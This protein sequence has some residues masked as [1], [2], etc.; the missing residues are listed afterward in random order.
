MLLLFALK[1]H[2]CVSHE[3]GSSNSFLHQESQHFSPD[4][5]AIC[6]PNVQTVTG[7]VVHSSRC[8]PSGSWVIFNGRSIINTLFFSFLHSITGF[9]NRAGCL[10]QAEE[11]MDYRRGETGVTCSP[12]L[13]LV[14]CRGDKDHKFPLAHRQSGKLRVHPVR[15]QSKGLAGH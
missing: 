3:G 11:K 2:V 10:L 13:G 7:A 15:H 9:Y 5:A 12:S 1:F 14:A 8:H 6:S 4:C